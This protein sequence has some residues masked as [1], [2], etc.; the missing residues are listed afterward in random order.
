M[1][2]FGSSK[3]AIRTQRSETVEAGDSL[4][5]DDGAVV[6]GADVVDGRAVGRVV[7]DGLLADSMSRSD[8]AA[9]FPPQAAATTA[10]E[11]MAR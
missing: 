2:Q 3:S 1:N 4:V 10:T 7:V 9:K 5:D 8:V 11:A 6:V